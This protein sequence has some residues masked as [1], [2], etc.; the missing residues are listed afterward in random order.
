MRSILLFVMMYGCLASVSAQY[1]NDNLSYKTVYLEDLCNSL[2]QHPDYL[3][4]DVR[5]AGEFADTSRFS[6]ANIGSLQNAVNIDIRELDKRISELASFKQKPIFVYCSHSQRSRRA[7]TLLAENGF[8]QVFNINE[9]MT[10]FNL[11][12]GNT[13]ACASNLYS[14]K[15]GYRLISANDLVNLLKQPGKATLFDLRSDSAYRG[16][17]SN[18]KL[19]AFGTIRGGIHVTSK[20]ALLEKSAVL[21]KTNTIVLVDDYGDGSME[22]A[23]LLVKEGFTDIR[24]L[25]EGMDKW[26]ATVPEDCPEKSS[27]WTRTVPY[28]VITAPELDQWAA[29]NTGFLMMDIRDSTQFNNHA[30]ESYLNKGHIKNAVN[31]PFS[32]VKDLMSKTS[33]SRDRPVLLY[34]FASQ[35]ETFKTARMLYDMGFRR[36]AVLSGGIFGIRWQAANIKGRSGLNHWVTDIP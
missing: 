19:N 6:G 27:W 12:K 3:F 26:M 5:S 32:Q 24:V 25:L 30:K 11:K 22:A 34:N 18:E 10:G 13:I 16:I 14:T 21:P 7:S 9:G 29:N 8:T 28:S 1:K 15:N 36:V 35:P 20:E 2:Q 17:S 31:I 23:G 4:L 33:F